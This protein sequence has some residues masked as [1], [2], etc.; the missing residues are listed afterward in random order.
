[1]RVA[2]VAYGCSRCL[3][4]IRKE[5]PILTDTEIASLV[6]DIEQ[7]VA[8]G[9][10]VDMNL[11]RHIGWGT[12]ATENDAVHP[13]AEEAGSTAPQPNE[14]QPKILENNTQ[15]VYHTSTE[16]P[17]VDF[18]NLCLPMDSERNHLLRKTLIASARAERR[19]VAQH[20]TY[21]LEKAL[22]IVPAVTID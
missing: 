12:C 2:S 18:F 21:L 10:A 17:D 1:M 5:Q 22:G 3:A 19:S 14:T 16:F 9:K 6:A 15:P 4:R 11:A 7:T 8:E 13:L 20:F